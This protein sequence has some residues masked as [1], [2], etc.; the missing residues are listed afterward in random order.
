M[1][2]RDDIFAD[3]IWEEVPAGEVP[4]AAGTLSTPSDPRL[5]RPVPPGLGRAHPDR[6]RQFMPFAA[7]RG[8]YDLVHEKEAAPEP[9]RPL[10]E[11]EARALDAFIAALKRGESVRCSFYRGGAYHVCEGVVSQVDVVCR[12]LWIVRTRIPFAEICA[13]D[14]LGAAGALR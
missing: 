1:D 12:D 2:S 11:E 13:L 4:S 14:Y 3:L 9:R 8:Y 5:T 7:L 6:A 10:T